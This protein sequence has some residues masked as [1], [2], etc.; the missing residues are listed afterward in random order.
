MSKEGFTFNDW[1]TA[2]HEYGTEWLE[3]QLMVLQLAVENAKL[4]D[5]HYSEPQPT[6]ALRW[7][8]DK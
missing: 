7:E 2:Y 1:T 5:K 8:Y 4:L 6:T 3:H